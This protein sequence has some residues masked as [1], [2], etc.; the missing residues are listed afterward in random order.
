[1]QRGKQPLTFTAKSS[2]RISITGSTTDF[3]IGSVDGNP[4][5]EEVNVHSGAWLSGQCH[6]EDR[7]VAGSRPHTVGLLRKTVQWSSRH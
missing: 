4:S 5:G 1:M 2:K 6:G 7:M 3:Y